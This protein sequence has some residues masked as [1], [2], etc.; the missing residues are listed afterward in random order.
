MFRARDLQVRS[1]E[2]GRPQSSKDDAPQEDGD[3]VSKHGGQLAAADAADEL[4]DFVEPLL[5][6]RGADDSGEGGRCDRGLLGGESEMK[7]LQQDEADCVVCSCGNAFE[8]W[9]Q[10]RANDPHLDCGCQH[11]QQS[12]TQ[13]CH[14]DC[15]IFALRVGDVVLASLSGSLHDFASQERGIVAK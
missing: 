8:E 1:C 4:R 7:M 5:T 9:G 15:P 6:V 2:D 12:P 11:G 3:Q 14:P 13:R 10:V